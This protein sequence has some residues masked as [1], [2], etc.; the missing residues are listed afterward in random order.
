MGSR[1]LYVDDDRANLVV[2]EAAFGDEVEVLTAGSGAEALVL[3]GTH[4]DVALLLTDQRMPGMSGTQL[5]EIVHRDHPDIVRYLITAYSDLAA[6][7]DAIN[8]GQVHRY[9]RKPWDP[10]EM[11]VHLREGLELHA[12]RTRIREL[13]R[14][15]REVERVYALGVVAA[16]IVHELR[17]PLSVVMGY[18][19]LARNL[20]EKLATLGGPAATAAADDLE[21]TLDGTWEAAQ[22]MGEIIRG[23]ELSTRRQVGTARSDLGEVVSL[24]LRMV[25]NELRHRAMTDTAIE[26][27][28]VVAVAGTQ[29]GQ[30]ALNLLINAMQAIPEGRNPEAAHITARVGPGRSGMARFEVVDDGRGVPGEMK[31]KIFDPFFTTKDEGGTGLGLAISKQ[32]IEEAGG[33]LWVE[34]TPGGGATFIVELPLAP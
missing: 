12:M 28:L 10:Q 7:I 23:V 29:L 19:D 33:T 1:I 25:I 30:V 26:M 15:L 31:E 11:R 9:L 22:R 20:R 13:E 21:R 18:V 16:S 5:A 4:R 3:L 17:N 24:T 2:F 32:I 14:R 8:L 34:D 27:G 6:A